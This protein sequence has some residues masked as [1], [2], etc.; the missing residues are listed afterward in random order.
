MHLKKLLPASLL[1]LAVTAVWSADTDN[2]PYPQGKRFP[3][4][5]YSIGSLAEMKLEAPF[6]WNIAH[7][8]SMKPEYLGVVRDAGWFTL[9]HLDKGDEA[10]TKATITDLPARG[11]VAWWDLPEE[12]RFWRTDEYDVVKNFSAWTRQA[13]PQQHPNFMY[14]PN[15]YTADGIAKYV[16]YLDIIGAGTY[17]E[18]AHEPRPW[19]RWRMEETIR[20]IK[21]AGYVIGADYRQK[22]RVP[23]GIP[24]LFCNPQQMRVMGP[25]EAYHDFYSCLAAGARGILI[26]S[27]WHKR[28]VGVLQQAY[29]A[30]AKGAAE[31]SGP[32]N[33][34]QALLFGEDVPLSFVITDGPLQTV[35]FRPTGVDHDLS[36]PSLNLRAVKYAGQLFIVAV[37]SSEKPIKAKISGLPAGL[38]ALRVP[39][40]RIIGPDRKPTADI[41]T[42]PVKEGA[43]EE[44]FSWLGVHI[45]KAQLP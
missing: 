17:T 25:V 42:V 40:E 41:R 33:L 36:Y 35:N 2:L 31:V 24:M 43:C 15:H 8:Y 23:I 14:L 32:E 12:M 1:V 13:D 44:E 4:G 5:L 6:G 18:Y 20:G 27:Y 45:Y 9:A 16:P 21:L 30:Y 11:P 29:E 34:G 28:D 38:T 39:F 10:T 7:T 19:V 37:N 22:G 3:L 26:F